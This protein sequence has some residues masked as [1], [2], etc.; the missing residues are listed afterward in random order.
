MTTPIFISDGGLIGNIVEGLMGITGSLFLSLM[1]I[2]IL[3]IVVALAMNIPV[4]IIAI[5]YLPIMIVLAAYVG[6]FKAMFG[7]IL[8]MA[9]FI[10]ADKLFPRG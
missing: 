7:C 1:V 4:E 8:I 10:L 5:I 2:M 6:D 9:G 3:L